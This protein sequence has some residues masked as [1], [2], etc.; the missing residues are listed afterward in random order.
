MR[1]SVEDS[2]R[3]DAWALQR[4]ADYQSGKVILWSWV[5]RGLLSLDHVAEW[6]FNNDIAEAKVAL[7]GTPGQM[8][9]LCH[10]DELPHVDCSSAQKEVA[11]AES[12]HMD[13]E[14]VCTWAS[15]DQD[16]INATPILLPA[17]FRAPIDKTVLL[18]QQEARMWD[19]KISERQLQGKDTL[20]PKQQKAFDAW[21]ETSSRSLVLDKK[22]R[23]QVVNVASKSIASLKRTCILVVIQLSQEASE[24][25]IKSGSGKQWQLQ[26]LQCK[27]APGESVPEEIDAF[28]EGSVE[29]STVVSSHCWIVFC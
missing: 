5:S 13:G 2:L 14:T 24:L 17:W 7:A 1:M 4:I 11:I 8:A 12:T 26:L 3:A 6:Y 28:Q 20:T 10:V 9:K 19:K 22:K 16:D 15:R 23:A 27:S 21:A 29:Y 25:K 18:W